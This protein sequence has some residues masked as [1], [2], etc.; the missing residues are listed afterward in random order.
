MN[1]FT[2][3]LLELRIDIGFHQPWI[4]GVAVNMARELECKQ[5]V[6]SRGVD[7]TFYKWAVSSTQTSSATKEGGGD[8]TNKPTRSVV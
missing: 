3:G 2:A 7:T 5:S 1:L 4:L 6:S 8:H